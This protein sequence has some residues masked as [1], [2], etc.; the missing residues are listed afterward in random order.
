MF[1]RQT[2]GSVVCA[3]CG[4]LVGVNDAKCYNCGRNNPGLWGY[5]GAIRQLGN[6]MGFVQIVL[7]GSSV[8]Y[9]MTLLMS[10][11]RIGMSGL[12]LLAPSDLALFRF[13]ASGAIPV[14]L[15]DRWW[16]VLSAGWL[17]GSLLHIVFNMLWVRQLGPATAEVF[18]AGRMVI[19]YTIAGVT[20]F[21]M[22]STAGMFLPDVPL[23]GG[24]GMTVGASASVF[25]LL[26]A[27]VAY[28]K[29]RG[30]SAETS[31]ALGYALALFLFGLVM[32]GVDNWA[33]AGGFV[34]GYLG[35]RWLDPWKP[36]RLNHL[37]A[38]LVCLAAS[39]LAIVV[40]IVH[41]SWAS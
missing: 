30:S 21:F 40:S 5:A 36:E 6:D 18:G 11:G 28:G 9:V 31:Q 20:G 17:H 16:T 41:Y 4:S 34:G 32:S 2:S 12:N 24:A 10:N 8:L 33:H 29:L 13:G 38:A 19:I 15:A 25:G 35:A 14:Y 23:L 39:A 37:V 1:R 7:I 27:L 3:S 22:S 26:G